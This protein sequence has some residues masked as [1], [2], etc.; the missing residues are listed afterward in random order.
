MLIAEA[1]GRFHLQQQ[2]HFKADEALGSPSSDVE[3]FA[4]AQTA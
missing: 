4:Y 1:E 3:E 2:M